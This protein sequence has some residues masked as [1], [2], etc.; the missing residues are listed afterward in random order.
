MASPNEPILTWNLILCVIAFP[1]LGFF[2]RK[3]IVDTQKQAVER[4]ALL[5]DE[6]KEIKACMGNVKADVNRKVDKTDCQRMSEEKW[7]RI[8]KHRHTDEGAVVIV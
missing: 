8:N 3:L 7:E 4:Y 2:I 5:H 1:S 6:I